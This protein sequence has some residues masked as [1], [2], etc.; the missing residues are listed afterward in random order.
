MGVVITASRLAGVL[1]VLLTVDRAARSW[2]L[3]LDEAAQVMDLRARTRPGAWA[4]RIRRKAE[5]RRVALGLPE[6]ETQ[7]EQ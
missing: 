7:E 4:E 6:P 2:G 5:Q 3:S 1:A